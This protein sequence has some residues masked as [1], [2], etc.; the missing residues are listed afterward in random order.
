MAVPGDIS[1]AAF[2]LV[3]AALMADADATVAHVGT[4]PTRTGVLEVLAA[5]GAAIVRRARRA[6]GRDQRVGEPSR[7]LSW[8]GA[9]G[10]AAPRSAAP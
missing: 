5:M 9:G 3:A 6:A 8:S 7:T 10:S 2:F 4:N 1:S